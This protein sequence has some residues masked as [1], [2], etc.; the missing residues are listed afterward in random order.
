MITLNK[1]YKILSD[2]LRGKKPKFKVKKDGKTYIYK[3]GAINYEIWAE[4]IAEQLGIQAGINM[5]H[6]RLASY[7]NTFG[8]LTD[9][10]LEPGELIISCDNLKKASR[11]D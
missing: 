7:N 11:Q 2:R 6:Y 4:L 5:A 10:F 1:E 8:V 9:Y 3:Y